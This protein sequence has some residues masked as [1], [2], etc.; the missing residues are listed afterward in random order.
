[1]SG[2]ARLSWSMSDLLTAVN[3]KFSDVKFIRFRSVDMSERLIHPDKFSVVKFIRYRSA[4]MSERCLG[5]N[6]LIG[7]AQTI[8]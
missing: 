2:R 8:V 7:F 5:D 1:V 6:I 3:D 4:D